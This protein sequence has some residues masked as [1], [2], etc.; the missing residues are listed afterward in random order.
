MTWP[1]WCDSLLGI[2]SSMR[3]AHVDPQ[4]SL[5]MQR[6]TQMHVTP[7][8]LAEIYPRA[9][10]RIHVAGETIEPGVYTAPARVRSVRPVHF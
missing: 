3:P 2:G 7:D 1:S 8:L 5:Q 4:T 6:V 10:V 9:D